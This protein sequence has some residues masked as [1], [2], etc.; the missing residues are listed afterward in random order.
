IVAQGGIK[1]TSEDSPEYADPNYQALVGAVSSDPNPAAVYLSPPRLM[2]SFRLRTGHPIVADFKSHP[3]KDVEIL[4]WRARLQWVDGFLA[5][6]GC[7]NT[8]A[9]YHFDRVVLPRL[10]STTVQ[11]DALERCLLD[12][13][14]WYL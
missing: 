11:T 4:D 2:E 1:N 10:P 9:P 14:R 13:G 5:G 7:E 3:F 6:G 8:R 12:S